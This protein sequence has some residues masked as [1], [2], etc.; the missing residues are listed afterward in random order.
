[1]TIHHTQKVCTLTLFKTCKI[2]KSTRHKSFSLHWMA[3]GANTNLRLIFPCSV[4]PGSHCF[5]HWTQKL[6]L[7]S[8]GDSD[9]QRTVDQVNTSP[10]ITTFFVL[11]LS[12]FLLLGN[13]IRL[14]ESSRASR[15]R[16]QHKE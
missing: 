2:G 6:N 5:S 8:V 12:P 1:M 16:Q 14:R 11:S 10:F 13:L 15:L 3:N 7:E 4:V 9:I